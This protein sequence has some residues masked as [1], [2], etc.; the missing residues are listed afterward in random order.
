MQDNNNTA[1]IKETA[2]D[3]NT[4]SNPC[5]VKV[6]K[7]KKKHYWWRYLTIF[8]LGI[9]FTI[10]SVCGGAAI[11]SSVMTTSQVL[12]AVNVNPDTY[13]TEKY[14]NMT[15]L[16]LIKGIATGG[17]DLNSL[18]GL[19]EVT[20]YVQQLFDEL[21]KMLQQNFGFTIDFNDLKNV[22][23]SEIGQAF[24]NEMKSSITIA[25]LM[26]VNE[27]SPLV[28]KYISFPKN[29][30]GTYNM[31]NPYSLDYLMANFNDMFNN[32]VL[33][34]VVD[35][36]GSTTLSNLANK[37]ISNLANEFTTMKISDLITIEDTAPK[38]LKF[39]GNLSL[40]SDFSEAINSAKIDDLL[41]VGSKGILYN[42][43]DCTISGI[44][45]Q[46]ESKTLNQIIDIPAYG[47]AN[48]NKAL[49]YL[50]NYTQSGLAAALN[51]AKVKD[52]FDVGDDPKEMLYQLQD[53]RLDELDSNLELGEVLYIDGD[54][55]SVLQALKKCPLNELSKT[56][57]TLKIEQVL[58]IDE[59]D[60][61]TSQVLIALKNNNATLSNLNEVVASL[62]INDMVKPE[63]RTA[64]IF[65]AIGGCTLDNLDSTIAGLK[66]KDAIL[67]DE[68]DP[69]TSPI[70][71]SLANVGINSADITKAIK[72]MSLEV[73]LN[74]DSTSP[75]VLW[76]LK[77]KTIQDLNQD[78][79]NAIEL[80]SIFTP[81]QIAGSKIITSLV[82][83]GAT[84]GN[85]DEVLNSLKI[86]EML[87][88]GDNPS[89][90]LLAIA[91]CDLT[92]LVDRINK[93]TIDDVFTPEEK[94][95]N[96][97]LNAL[98]G[99]TLLS[100]LGDA[101]NDL[102]FV[103]VFSDIVYEEDHTTLK[104]TWAFLLDDP[105]DTS[106]DGKP[107]TYKLTSTWMAKMITNFQ[108]NLKRATLYKLQANGF[109]DVDISILNKKII[110]DENPIGSYTIAQF[111]AKLS[112]YL[113]TA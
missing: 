24:L 36:S 41:D 64:H 62:S 97:F 37:K 104:G 74:L 92:N 75:G 82:N 71:I 70:L 40:N 21:N 16:D 27:S 89:P 87:D 69:N 68:A 90:L 54:S 11:V 51:D 112:P 22:N 105:D 28:L 83:K 78:T 98:P 46:I 1:P 94:A 111:I 7:K 60:P 12:S 48:Y 52:L 50:G 113:V 108:A 106:D 103:A 42:L 67:I 61:N 99:T 84:V 58:T 91:E 109:L 15:L 77:D 5:I 33:S 49:E 34:D 110:G 93:L 23:W 100:K 39:I 14:Q 26:Q 57:S 86:K 85:I 2:N 9:L 81:E 13:L 59:T 3:N 35:C 17:V 56:I 107:E 8:F 29:E 95:A 38:A 101:I 44:S 102:S 96:A 76:A 63:K 10:G 31:S 45:T 20:P 65:N 55:S 47:E 43:K 6:E 32:M 73:L 80:G 25:G 72:S 66:L 30:D 88:L 53:K 19:S 79:I 4:M 18:G